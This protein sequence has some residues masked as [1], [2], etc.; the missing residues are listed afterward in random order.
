[1]TP[2]FWL[3]VMQE[4]F[5]VEERLW[6]HLDVSA[7]LLWQIGQCN[8][9]DASPEVLIARIKR[10]TEVL[11]PQLLFQASL[12]VHPETGKPRHKEAIAFEREVLR[13]TNRK[14]EFRFWDESP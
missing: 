2:V 11:N 10:L 6:R 14:G 9:L 5:F 7:T 12:A 3:R 1:V 4:V 8:T 13:L